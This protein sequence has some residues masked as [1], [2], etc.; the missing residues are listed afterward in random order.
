MVYMS[1]LVI[2]GNNCINREVCKKIPY[3]IKN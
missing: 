2:D 3:W 1:F